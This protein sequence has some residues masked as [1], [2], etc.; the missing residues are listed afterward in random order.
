M[1]EPFVGRRVEITGTSR[2]DLNGKRGT[3]VSFDT[4]KGRYRVRVRGSDMY[5][6]PSNLLPVSETDVKDQ[7]EQ[8]ADEFM[9]R[10]KDALPP[11]FAPRDALFA[12]V[13][14]ALLWRTAGLVRAAVLLLI[15]V[16]ALFGGAREAYSRAG[17]GV[18]GVKAGADAAGTFAAKEVSRRAGR[19]VTSKQAWMGLAL[20][21]LLAYQ[22]GGA[23][24]AAPRAYKPPRSAYEPS[25]GDS[26]S[27]A[28]RRG[29]DD[30]T[31]G[32]KYDA[33]AGG[34]AYDDEPEGHE[35][36]GGMGSALLSK[37]LPLFFFGKQVH[38]L[39]GS[40]WN[41][42]VAQRNFMALD[43]MRKAM[44]GFLVLRLLGLSPL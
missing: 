44:F 19:P 40:P 8:Y 1:S 11:G 21:V 17:G 35:P 3:A 2:A 12:I 10:L 31:A 14:F 20:L 27:D 42:Q 22:F 33:D 6:K 13:G 39:G 15:T 18:A 5:L 34:E 37:G 36:S 7:A 30:A 38:Q 43:P 29:F 28:Y 32:R 4:D 26:C 41:P 16:V 24:K 23:R 25:T 9:S